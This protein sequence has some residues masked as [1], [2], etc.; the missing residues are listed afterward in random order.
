LDIDLP[1]IPPTAEARQPALDSALAAI[2]AADPAFDERVLLQRVQAEFYR[3][4][5]SLEERNP[6]GLKAYLGPGLL[7]TWRAVAQRQRDQRVVLAIRVL[8]I[9][10]LRLM[11][12]NH[13]PGG[14]AVTVGIDGS[15]AVVGVREGD[16][17]PLF[18]D[19][20]PQP[21]TEYWT[22]ARAAGARTNVDTATTCPN[23]GAPASP[24][25]GALCRYCSAGL[26][27]PLQGWTL[28]R[29]D[30]RLEWAEGPP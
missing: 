15:A 22:W 27:G 21:L 12:A 1:P 9:D 17:Q 24:Q 25:D 13:G 3:V 16:G 30:E 11:W 5:R 18:G 19:G 14:D 7:Q 4:K 10:D 23:C 29:V 20:R 26:P 8:Q 6:D 2:R 28:V